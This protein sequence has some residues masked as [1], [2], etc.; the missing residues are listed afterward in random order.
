VAVGS[1]VAVGSRVAVGAAVLGGSVVAGWSGAWSAGDSADEV[2]TGGPPDC[3]A[4]VG[5]AVG[6]PS[7]TAQADSETTI[8]KIMKKRIIEITSIG[9][10]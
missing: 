5:A 1:G 2:E 4:S 9:R 10:K 8:R 3:A 6:S 7:A